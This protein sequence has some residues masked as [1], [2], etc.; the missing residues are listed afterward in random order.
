MA[1]SSIQNRSSSRTRNFDVFVSFRGEDTRNGFTGHL[2]ASLQRKGVVAF[3]DDQ[4]IKKGELLEPELLQAIEGSRVFIVVFSKDYA[5]STW[6][7]KELTKIVDWVEETGRSVL[8]VFYD[9]TPSEVRKQSGKFERAFV[10]HE[11]RPQHEEI[12]KVVD[13]VTNILGHNQILCF[14]DDLVDMHSRVKQLEELLDLVQ[15]KMDLGPGIR[16]VRS[17]L[18]NLKALIILDNVDKLEQLEKLALLP[19]NLELLEYRGFCPDVG[20]KVLIEK[21][22]ISYKGPTIMMHDL[23]K[24]LGKSIEA[25]NLEAVVI[26]YYSKP[27]DSTLTVDGLSKMNQ[28]N[29]LILQGVK[30]SGILN[31]LSNELRYILWIGSP[32]TSLPSSFYPDRLVELIMPRSKIKHLWEGTKIPD[33]KGIPHLKHLVLQGCVEMV[34]ID[35][36]VGILKELTRLNLKDCKNLVL[37][38]GIIFGIDSL[39]ELDLSGCPKLFDENVDKNTNDIKFST[40]SPLKVLMFPFQF[41]SSPKAAEDSSALSLFYLL[42]PPH[43]VYLDLSFCNILK[44]PDAIGNSHALASLNLGGNKFVTLPTTINQLSKL[45]FLNLEHCKQLKHLPELPI[46][47]EETFG[48]SD[49]GIFIFDCPKLS[50]ME[51]YYSMIFSTTMQHLQSQSG[52]DNYFMVPIIFKRDLVT[53][54][55]DHL[56]V[57]FFSRKFLV[58]HLGGSAPGFRHPCLLLEVKGWGYRCLFEEDLQPL[59]SNIISNATSSSSSSRKRKLLTN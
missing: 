9:I 36:S 12:E 55:L 50:E 8:P 28:L 43:L 54:E 30:S 26:D 1:S 23:L 39:E 56:L 2:F 11:E 58:E 32:F 52:I 7:M 14:G 16:L 21:S 17:R 10:E 33:L 47:K 59:K 38:L 51:K 25:K 41:F 20:L 3:R 35:P 53:V 27:A 57:M 34:R 44:I 22:L 46:L 13:E 29:F 42:Y 31:H 18:S 24:E 19:T 15:M 5:S 40:P 37:D 49:R 48:V 4:K 6:C 45:Q